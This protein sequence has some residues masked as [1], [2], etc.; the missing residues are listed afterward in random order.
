MQKRNCAALNARRLST[1][2]WLLAL[3][4]DGVASLDTLGQLARQ[5]DEK[6]VD[7]LRLGP[8]RDHKL[9]ALFGLVGRAAGVVDEAATASS[10]PSPGAGIPA[11]AC[12]R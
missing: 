12:R 10:W 2:I 6:L 1:V 7:K 11:A 8:C 5:I 3:Q 9:L 4:P